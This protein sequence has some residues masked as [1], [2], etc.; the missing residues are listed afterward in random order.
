ML[1]VYEKHDNQN[2][3]STTCFG[4]WTT[5]HVDSHKNWI[6]RRQPDIAGHLQVLE[7]W[8]WSRLQVLHWEGHVKAWLHSVHSASRF[9]DLSSWTH[10]NTLADCQLRELQRTIPEKNLTWPLFM[11]CDQGTWM[12]RI[13]RRVVVQTCVSNSAHA[14]LHFSKWNGKRFQWK[15][16]MWWCRFWWADAT[17]NTLKG[18][19]KK[20]TL[21]K[22]KV[23]VSKHLQSFNPFNPFNTPTFFVACNTCNLQMLK[24][25][26]TRVFSA[27]NPRF[28]SFILLVPYFT[29]YTLLSMNLNKC[30][31]T[32]VIFGVG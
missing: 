8:F 29:Y 22:Y 10:K 1:L 32:F 5:G 20:V 12:K 26:Q 14:L 9:W 21:K 18:S 27:A 25:L 23:N 2:L 4:L 17:L 24:M 13:K 19:C 28:T 3:I 15:L 6:W 30:L 7:I 31:F 16:E 11:C